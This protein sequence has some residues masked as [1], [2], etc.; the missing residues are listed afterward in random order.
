MTTRLS[1]A[2]TALYR[3]V[4]LDAA[5]E[6]FAEHGY[7][8]AKMQ[9]VSKAAGASLSTVYNLFSTKEALYAAN[10]DRRLKALFGELAL[11]SGGWLNQPLLASALAGMA[12]WIRFHLAHPNYLRMH[13]REGT[14]W[15]NPDTLRSNVQRAA[16]DRGFGYMGQVFGTLMDQ[17]FL[18]R[19]DPA[20]VARMSVAMQQ[21][22][23]ARWVEGTL[24]ETPDQLIF[25]LQETFLRAFAEPGRAQEL[26]DAWLSEPLGAT[27]ESNP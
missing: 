19:D 13:L 5:E 10:H 11:D 26:I 14:A 23:M 17:G 12:T 7:D 3:E 8:A 1:D 4:L 15:A 22:R 27:F 2:K 25:R 24:D 9:A 21:V 6:V 20:V 16:W 18:K